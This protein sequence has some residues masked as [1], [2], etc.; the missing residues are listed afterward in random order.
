MMMKIRNWTNHLIVAVLL[1]CPT[2]IAIAQN[3]CPA[4]TQFLKSQNKHSFA[5]TSVAHPSAA[6]EDEKDIVDTAVSAGSFKTLVAAIEAADLVNVLKGKGPF[7]VFA[8]SD[9]AFAKLPEG[10]V[11]MLLKPENKAKLVQILT[12]HVVAGRIDAAKVVSIDSAA[13]VAGPSIN[14]MA[15][16]K[17]VMVDNANVVA[18][19]ISCS[20]G[21]I[22]V[23]D[24]V[25]MPRDIVDTAISSGSFNTLVA[26]VKAAGLAETLKGDGPFTVFAPTDEAFA[27]LPKETLESLLKPENRDKLSAILTYHVVADRVLAADVVKIDSAKT[28][29]GKSVKISTANDVV[30]VNGAKVLKTDVLGSNGVIHVIDSVLLPR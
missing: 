1:T 30:M 3:N 7:T 16:N 19:D 14:I 11:E 21:L 24:A 8:P 12:Y 27:K 26:A 6:N 25:I 23:I 9:E 17:G 15:G 10:T 20:N 18:T 28:V 4:S 2:S 5:V 29:N 13:S 22:H